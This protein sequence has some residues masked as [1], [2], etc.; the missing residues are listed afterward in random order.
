MATG[1]MTVAHLV[2]T[3]GS[4][5][6]I[7][8]APNSKEKDSTVVTAQAIVRWLTGSELRASAQHAAGLI[9]HYVFGASMATVYGVFVER[10]PRLAVGGVPLGC[11][12]WLGA[13]VIAVPALGLAKPVSESSL[14]TE[15]AELGAHVIYGA[16]CEAVRHRVR[17]WLK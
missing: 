3:K 15:S 8:S 2:V 4:G 16:A 6:A 5:P 11:A 7:D 14:V 17:E 13:H 12:I 1:A 9:V 10:S